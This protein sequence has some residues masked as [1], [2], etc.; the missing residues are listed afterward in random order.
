MARQNQAGTRGPPVLTMREQQVVELA[1]MGHH[2]KL[3][4]YNLGVSHSTV[5]V[6]IARAARKLQ[7]S[8]RNDLIHRYALVSHSEG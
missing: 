8:S 5:R 7:S 4:A 6:L 2:N 1:S 3:I